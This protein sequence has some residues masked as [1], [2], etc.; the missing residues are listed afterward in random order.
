M[1]ESSSA[2]RPLP[3]S[4]PLPPTKP[5]KPSPPPSTNASP[6]PSKKPAPPPRS[7]KPKTEDLTPVDVAIKQI[8][9]DTTEIEESKEVST[10]PPGKKY[11]ALSSTSS[12][13]IDPTGGNSTNRNQVKTDPATRPP[14][15]TKPLP[16]DIGPYNEHEEAEEEEEEEED[17]SERARP[18]IR[19]LS[20]TSVLSQVSRPTN[21]RIKAP[22]VNERT[23]DSSS[24][25]SVSKTSTKRKFND[26]SRLYVPL[27]ELGP[28]E[29]ENEIY[30][31]VRFS[32][33]WMWVFIV[34]HI[35]QMS[36]LL[37]VGYRTMNSGSFA[38]V[39]LLV[40]TVPLLLLSSRLLIRK[41]RMSNLRNA[42]FKGGVCTPDDEKDEVPDRAVLLV[43]WAAVLEGIIY[44]IYTAVSAGND[45]NLD[46]SGLYTQDTMLQTLRFASLLLL[47][48]HRVLRPANRVDPLRTILDLE[49]VAVCWDALDGSTLFE[50]LD[51]S[52]VLV[53]STRNATRV[54]M[55]FWYLSVG[56]RVALMFF[57]H[58]SPTSPTYRTF[59]TAPLQLAPQPT[60]DRTLQALRLRSIVTCL[61]VSADLY[62]AILRLVLWSDGKLNALQQDMAIKNVMFLGLVGFAIS[63][64]LNTTSRRWNNRQLLKWP[65]MLFYP[66]RDTQLEIT[67]WTFSV[68]YLVTASFLTVV[69][70]D[71]TDSSGTWG[72]NLAVD[73]FLVL[74]FLVYC[75][76]VYVKDEVHNPSS[77]LCPKT[78]F[79][80]FPSRLGVVLG[81]LFVFSL[82]AVRLPSL[83]FAYSDISNDDAQDDQNDNGWSYDTAMLFVILSVIPIGLYAFYWTVAYMLFRKE[84]TASPGNYLAI[85]DPAVKAV[86]VASISEGV[87]DVLSC[88]T[89]MQLATSDLPRALNAGVVMFCLL[90]IAN[91]CQSFSLQCMLSGGNDD[92]PVDVVR[93]NA[94]LRVSRGLIDFGTIVLRLVLWINYSAVSS[95][96][97]VKNIYNLTHTL[98]QI[99][100]WKGSTNYPKGTLF[101]EFVP[102]A[103]WYGMTKTEWRTATSRSLVQQARAGRGV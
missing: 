64:F 25:S 86:A 35:V 78:R 6:I 14:K 99:E 88:A 81:G 63:N 84:F 93:W 54:L 22:L 15:A 95:V 92:T 7:M 50:L 97:L 82:L 56:V 102:P 34:V 19:P 62:A 27:T 5:D 66:N 73:G 79:F 49:L 90:E 74:I 44:A 13:K 91:A 72:V 67:R 57:T 100:R 23:S 52:V 80:I 30:H 1:S 53:E 65:F 83:Y 17:D 42:R 60:V 59:I 46:D 21:D 10:N 96:F 11:K 32:E 41:S 2:R 101:S 48:L 24:V 47:A 85:H 87:L 9:T 76:N 8:S 75:K 39:L 12:E 31:K 28:G 4:K 68:A 51:G 71:V 38:V 94:Y 20:L 55:S 43:A 103:D 69:L 3:Q 58:L 45:N 70:M 40:I 37:T 33:T 98:S 26:L 29:P 77:C 61:M 89:L 36:I 18:S 16:P